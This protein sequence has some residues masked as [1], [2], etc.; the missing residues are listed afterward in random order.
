MRPRYLEIDVRYASV[1]SCR[2]QP[3]PALRGCY[4]LRAWLVTTRQAKA[5]RT[6]SANRAYQ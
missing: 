5:Y 1:L 6:L 2:N 3:G 4:E